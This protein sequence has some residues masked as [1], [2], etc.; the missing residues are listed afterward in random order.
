MDVCLP[1]IDGVNALGKIRELSPTPP[2][3][4]IMTSFGSLDVAVRSLSAGAFDYLP[5]PF[6]LD[7]AVNVV[8]RALR[9][10]E[11]TR[12]PTE[13]PTT[14]GTAQLLGH[15]ARMQQVFKEIALVS[16]TMQL[17]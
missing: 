4:V 7:Q 5:K 3:V 1:G 11:T 2:P 12:K 8:Q 16:Q 14:L 6:D 17:C 15:S 10:S 13:T 9:R